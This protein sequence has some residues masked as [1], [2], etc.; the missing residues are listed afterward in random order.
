[1]QAMELTHR[2]S[3]PGLSENARKS[4]HKM[5]CESIWSSYE[6]I[7]ALTNNTFNETTGCLSTMIFISFIGEKLTPVPIT[8]TIHENSF[9]TNLTTCFTSSTRKLNPQLKQDLTKYSCIWS[10]SSCCLASPVSSLFYYVCFTFPSLP[11]FIPFIWFNFKLHYMEFVHMN[12]GRGWG[13][14]SFFILKS[15]MY[16]MAQCRT[17]KCTR[18]ASKCGKEFR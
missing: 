11:S 1:M 12:R 9:R 3:D 18:V 5:I 16:I 2:K 13:F 15:T 7:C 10:I 8:A 14:F 4:S 17:G 6:N